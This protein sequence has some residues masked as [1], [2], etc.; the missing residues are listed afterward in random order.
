MQITQDEEKLRTSLVSGFAQS[1]LTAAPIPSATITILENGQK[2]ETNN[3]GLFGPIPWPIGA[4]ITLT[5]EKGGFLTT[6]SGTMIV[7]QAG[8]NDPL[9][10]I[11]FQVPSDF[12]VTL[13][14][15]AMGAAFNPNACTVATTVTAYNKTLFDIPQG[16]ADA[17]T[18]LFP[19]TSIKP[20]YFSIFEKGWL[21]DKTNP[22]SRNLTS[23][24][25]DG[26]VMYIN[27][28]PR[29]EPY[30]LKA[31]KNN[32]TFSEVTFKARPGIFINLSPPQGPMVQQNLHTST[33]TST[34]T[35]FS[36][37]K[38]VIKPSSEVKPLNTLPNGKQPFSLFGFPILSP[39]QKDFCE[40]L[41]TFK[42]NRKN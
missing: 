33:S 22:F 4:P 29:E 39:R 32:L 1:F 11:S 7:P 42:W 3:E 24:S 21:K 13:F 41:T 14:S 27:I 25:H 28:P 26:G 6:Q 38:K 12:A 15:Y 17:K 20:F 30:T 37:N 34:S 2:I 36:E 40:N 23:T 18:V 9:H 19:D 35:Y 16:E 5:L 8:L 31:F 10:N